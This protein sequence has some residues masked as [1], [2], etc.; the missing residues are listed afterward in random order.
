MDGETRGIE[1]AYQ[2]NVHHHAL[3]RSTPTPPPRP[4]VYPKTP[5]GNIPMLNRS[6]DPPKEPCLQHIPPHLS[7]LRPRRHRSHTSSN[8]LIPFRFVIVATSGTSLVAQRPQA[9]TPSPPLW[10][11]PLA[12]HAPAPLVRIDHNKTVSPPQPTSLLFS[13]F[14]LPDS[15]LLLF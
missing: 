1:H 7:A 12:T 3:S 10:T 2:Y 11:H 6:D 15:V 4:Q 13:F 9:P 14:L 8:P 5:Q